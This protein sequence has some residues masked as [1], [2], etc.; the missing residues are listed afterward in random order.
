MLLNCVHAWLS[1]QDF[2][3]AVLLGD[4][5][6]YGSSGYVQVNNVTLGTGKQKWKPVQVMIRE[7]SNTSWPAGE[8]HL[9]GPAF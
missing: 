7:I 9:P 2:S 4:P 6:V 8:V 1:E 3:F 5:L